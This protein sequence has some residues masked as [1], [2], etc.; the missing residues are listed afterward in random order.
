MLCGTCCWGRYPRHECE[1]FI[2][3]S[4][5]WKWYAAGC[6]VRCGMQQRGVPAEVCGLHKQL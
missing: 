4:L 6:G 5:G 3:Q 1:R 2:A